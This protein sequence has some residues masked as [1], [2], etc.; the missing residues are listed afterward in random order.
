MNISTAHQHDTKTD[1]MLTPENTEVQTASSTFMVK[2]NIRTVNH[3]E[4]IVHLEWFI[5]YP[6]EINVL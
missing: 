1:S 6:T 2:H 3:R 5:P 4:I